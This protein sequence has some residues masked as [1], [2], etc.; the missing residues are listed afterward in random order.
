MSEFSLLKGL[1]LIDYLV[2]ALMRSIKIK[3]FI[4]LY[5]PNQ[6]LKNFQLLF[7]DAAFQN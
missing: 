1:M 5:I 6:S 3:N 2:E 4:E 7:L